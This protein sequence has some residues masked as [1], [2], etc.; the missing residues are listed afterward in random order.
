MG[1]SIVDFVLFGIK[2]FSSRHKDSPAAIG[3]ALGEA[4]GSFALVANIFGS[5]IHRDIRF[6]TTGLSRW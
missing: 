3:F 1:S 4:G 6:A 5:P 2:L